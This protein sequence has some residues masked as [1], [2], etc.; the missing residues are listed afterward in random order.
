MNKKCLYLAVLLLLWAVQ[1]VFS[2]VE[3]SLPDLKKE[4]IRV[5][6]QE[7]TLLIKTSDAIWEFAE[8]ALLEFKSSKL[9]ADILE[10]KGFSVKREVA[11][12]PTAFVASYGSGKPVIGILAEYDA[13]PG[14]SQDNTSFQKA[15]VEGGSGHGCGHN[16]FGAGSLGA[17]LAIKEVME[18]HKIKGTIRLYGCGYLMIWTPVLPGIR[19]TRQKWMSKAARLSLI[20]RSSFSARLLMRPLT[21]GKDTVRLTLLK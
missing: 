21:P 1:P 15:L 16:L 5:I 8:T 9:L 20:S 10:K 2:A 17:A 12:L 18:S 4:V 13:L 7:T 3:K 11:D 6:D 14:L 19:I